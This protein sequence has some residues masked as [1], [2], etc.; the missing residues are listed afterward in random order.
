MAAQPEATAP[1]PPPRTFWQRPLLQLGS[2]ESKTLVG[3]G[4][5]G[6]G[7]AMAYQMGA[8][9]LRQSTDHVELQPPVEYLQ[10]YSAA[11]NIFAQLAEFRTHDETAYR[12]ALIHADRL[13]LLVSH[14][15]N[16]TLK[17]NYADS[18]QAFSYFKV[19]LGQVQ[20]LGEKAKANQQLR[21]TACI[22][23]L[24]KQLYP[25]MQRLFRL[26]HEAVHFGR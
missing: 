25:E 3:M 26:V 1:P 2:T 5:V 14:A 18:V 7:L 19:T 23:R 24:L 22:H 11:L 21:D 4:L 9:Y 13:A 10:H 17:L 6:A 20:L 8:L 15:Q 12:Q 16:R